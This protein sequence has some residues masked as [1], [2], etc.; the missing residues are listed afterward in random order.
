MQTLISAN[1]SAVAPVSTFP[2]VKAFWR[3][4]L[5]P[6]VHE[7]AGLKKCDCLGLINIKG[8]GEGRF[9]SGKSVLSR[10]DNNDNNRKE[11]K[12]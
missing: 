12:Q 10:K 9:P 7:D 2:K 11:T 3:S 5:D 1:E 8:A 4:W 6:I